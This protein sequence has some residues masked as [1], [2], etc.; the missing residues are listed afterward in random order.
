MVSRFM[1]TSERMKRVGRADTDLELTLR[2]ALWSRGIRYRVHPPG[3]D[4]RPDIAA[5]ARRVAVFI[6]GCFWHGC[7][8]CK[9]YPKTNRRFWGA[10]FR[11][12]RARRKQV[13]R[14][15][16]GQG[17]R[18]VEVWGHEIVEDLDATVARVAQAIAGG[19]RRYLAR[20]ANRRVRRRA[21]DR[22]V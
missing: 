12:N 8:R 4:G 10:K 9:D 15:L 7:P 13:R 3:V 14:E 19:P 5:R 17:W 11:Y 22:K 6:D 20:T 1:N 2:K 21:L 16:E 18:V